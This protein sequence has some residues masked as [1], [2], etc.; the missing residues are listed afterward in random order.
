VTEFNFGPPSPDPTPEQLARI[1]ERV[2]EGLKMEQTYARA[3]L[4]DR[5]G[6]TI[7]RAEV[8]VWKRM[9]D[10]GAVEWGGTLTPPAGAVLAVDRGRYTLRLDGRDF[11]IVMRD[12]PGRFGR[13][14]R[15]SATF[16]GSGAPPY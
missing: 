5:E 8:T 11:D 1:R 6:E 2:L 7:A 16:I 12:T 9:N 13:G 4:I 10:A 15:T 14:A 3:E